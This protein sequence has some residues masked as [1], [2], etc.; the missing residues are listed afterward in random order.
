MYKIWCHI[1]S[2]E[3]LDFILFYFIALGMY[4]SCFSLCYNKIPDQEHLKGG[5]SGLGSPRKSTVHHG[6][7]GTEGTA[8]GAQ[9]CLPTSGLTRKH[10]A[11]YPHLG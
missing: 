1:N 5:K 11:A 10:K 4:S 2:Q 3:A 8:A 7:E 9:G 6:W